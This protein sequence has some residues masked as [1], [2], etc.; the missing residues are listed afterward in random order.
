MSNSSS[1]QQGQQPSM[2]YQQ[3]LTAAGASSG[4][5]VFP[6]SNAQLDL[7]MLQQM[8]S[9]RAEEPSMQAPNNQSGWAQGS[10]QMPAPPPRQP[11]TS[12]LSPAAVEYSSN[13][14]LQSNEQVNLYATSNNPSSLQ[15]ASDPSAMA[16]QFQDL[17][18]FLQR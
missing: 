11:L 17:A 16:N 15:S 12:M 10:V 5:P 4:G 2:Q 14:G 6:S 3:Q 13:G 1:F 18:S 7:M 8:L 9:P